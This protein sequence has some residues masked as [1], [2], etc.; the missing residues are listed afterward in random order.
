MKMKTIG[1][2]I[3]KRTAL[4]CAFFVLSLAGGTQAAERV[5]EHPKPSISAQ[6]T[7][8]YE[9][10]HSAFPQGQPPQKTL[11]LNKD[12]RK[13]I[14]KILRHKY[15]LLRVKYWQ[16]DARTVWVLQEVGKYKP[17]TVGIIVDQGQIEKLSVLVY[18]ESH[19]WEVKHDFFT[20]QFVG[21]HLSHKLRIDQDI[22]GISG[23]TLSVRA[24]KK[25][26]RLAL[27]L[28]DV[29]QSKRPIIS[30]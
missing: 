28:D 30:E 17:I 6:D 10:V 7:K 29:V 8:I 2:K 11:W 19:G 9:F 22:D 24:L 23:A 21:A 18:R 26:A 15:G 1:S 4:L 13:N 5:K 16:E 25:T 12:L 3:R 20:R 14:K 27:Y